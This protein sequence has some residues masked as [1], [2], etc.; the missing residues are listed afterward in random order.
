MGNKGFYAIVNRETGEV[1][2]I[3]EDE[4]EAEEIVHD[5]FKKYPEEEKKVRKEN[6]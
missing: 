5:L 2:R 3:T 4:N 6:E 1:V